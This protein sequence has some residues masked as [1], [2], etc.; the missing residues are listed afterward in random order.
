M[1]YTTPGQSGSVKLDNYLELQGLS[2]RLIPIKGVRQNGMEGMV[3]TDIM[4][5][6]IV[7]KFKYTNLNNPKVYQDETC[8][9]MEQNMKNNFN[10]LAEA[11][12][13]EGKLEKAGA[14]LTKLEQAIPT[15][16]LGYVPQDVE[17]VNL[18][19]KVGNKEKGRDLAKFAFENIKD[20][21]DYYL[22]QPAD[23]FPSVSDDLQYTLYTMRS[24]TQ[25]VTENKEEDLAKEVEAKF[26]EYYSRFVT[27]SGGQR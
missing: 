12:I 19:F 17:T 5:E 16:V 14:V 6:N 10:R 22:S 8:R 23:I 26:N 24:L 15:K 2:Y 25:W 11:L 1:Y 20:E 9:R 13:A 27:R 21:A 18:W 3:N 4:Y 7:N